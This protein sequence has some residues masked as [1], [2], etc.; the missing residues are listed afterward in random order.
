MDVAQ[1]FDSEV[2]SFVILPL[3]IFFARIFDVSIG[4]IRLIFVSKGFRLLA[5]LLGFFEILI[6]IIAIGQIMQHLDNFIC[7]LAYALGFATGNYIGIRIEERL[8][9]GTVLVRVFPKKD[10][11]RLIDY[12][13]EN[14]YGVTAIDIEG[15]SGK[16][17]MFV[18]IINR[19][20]LKKLVG[21]I[22][23]YNPNAFFSVEDIR[24]VREGF[25]RPAERHRPFSVMNPFHRKSK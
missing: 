4:T 13:R 2:F 24:S 12:L 19:K 25:F 5:P 14:K 16:N 22:Q 10:T 20:D 18:S 3:L 17:Q 23:E 6:W 15:K 11:A 7:Y 8:S 1:L 9:I 21:I